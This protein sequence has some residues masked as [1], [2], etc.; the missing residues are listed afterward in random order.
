[1][2]KIFE[3]NALIS[4]NR[5][6]QS[7]EYSRSVQLKQIDCHNSCCAQ[8]F[9]I[10]FQTS[11]HFIGWNG[12]LRLEPVS[13][14]IQLNKTTRDLCATFHRTFYIPER[15]AHK[16]CFREHIINT[17]IGAGDLWWINQ[18]NNKIREIKVTIPQSSQRLTNITSENRIR[19]KKTLQ[20]NSF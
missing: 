14:K 13:I 20:K 15:V 16:I 11:N 12:E 4:S 17:H 5:T 18:I 1:M 10:L 2:W 19:G 9:F 8:S 7:M 6:A 3:T